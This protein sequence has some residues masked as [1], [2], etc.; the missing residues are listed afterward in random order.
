MDHNS[1]EGIEIPC[2]IV[3]FIMIMHLQNTKTEFQQSYFG[4]IQC[5]HASNLYSPS[6]I[7]SPIAMTFVR[8]QE[9]LVINCSKTEGYM[10]STTPNKE[11][12]ARLYTV[13]AHSNLITSSK[14]A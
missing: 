14:S 4:L 9:T 1:N 5:C 7:F 12:T 6:Y 2:K 10:N 8:E 13:H 11:Q 3:I